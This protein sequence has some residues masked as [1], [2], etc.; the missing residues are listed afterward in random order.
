[1]A[2]KQQHNRECKGL[3]VQIKYLKAKYTRES[4]FRCDL[5][6]QKQYLLVLMARL[7]R[8]CAKPDMAHLRAVLDDRSR[9]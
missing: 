7:G 5:A 4:A 3:M 1:M 2:L 6:Y 9:R 8:C